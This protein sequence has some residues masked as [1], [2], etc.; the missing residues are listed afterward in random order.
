MQRRTFMW[1]VL[2]PFYKH[3]LFLQFKHT[4]K[5]NTL[6]KRTRFWKEHAWVWLKK[7][8]GREGKR[9]KERRKMI[10]LRQKPRAGSQRILTGWDIL[11][12]V[13]GFLMPCR[14]NL[15]PYM[16]AIQKF[17]SYFLKYSRW[18]KGRNTAPRNQAVLGW[19]GKSG[20]LWL[21]SQ[22]EGCP[23]SWSTLGSGRQLSWV[24]GE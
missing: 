22:W 5:K 19:R 17:P 15:L 3:I 1:Y 18:G 7:R 8:K 13:A 12:L 4:F 10:S 6:L 23:G 11:L 20:R 14:Q 16:S 21:R 24:L 9:G 2:V